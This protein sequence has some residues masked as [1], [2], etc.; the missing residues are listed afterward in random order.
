MVET[1]RGPDPAGHPFW[2]WFGF[3]LQFLILGLVVVIGAFTGAECR[4][5]GDYVV[6]MLLIA[7]AVALA[8]LRLKHWFDGGS[9]GWGD[10][11]LVDDMKNLTIT[12]PIFA[13]I[14]LAG[15]FTAR[16]SPNGSL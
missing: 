9:P 10:Y 5:P 13:V 12:I 16:A 8:F 14:G 3:W 2:P 7:G 4:G 6:G 1:S 15:L 11:L